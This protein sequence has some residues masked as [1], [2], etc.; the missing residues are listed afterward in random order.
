MPT[1]K[2]T[3][4][5]SFDDKIK[6]YFKDFYDGKIKIPCSDECDEECDGKHGN[7]ELPS[8]YPPL[9]IK[10]VSNYNITSKSTQTKKAGQ[11]S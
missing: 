2:L 7:Y 10:K 5:I 11:F 4:V 3:S 9:F 1:I 8:N 6:K